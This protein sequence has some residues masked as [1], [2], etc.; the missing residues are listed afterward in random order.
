MC[1]HFLLLLDPSDF[2][3]DSPSASEIR[4]RGARAGGPS[5]EVHCIA[6]ILYPHA[7]HRL[8]GSGGGLAIQALQTFLI[9]I[10]ISGLLS[11]HVEKNPTI[12]QKE[13]QVLEK[14]GVNETFSKA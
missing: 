7:G 1:V 13:D 9:F 11:S 14:K 12:S 5:K 3:T 4:H 8:C 6:C 10:C 2:G